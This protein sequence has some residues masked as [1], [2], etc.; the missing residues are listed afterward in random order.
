MKPDAES[1]P[2]NLILTIKAGQNLIRLLYY[3][4]LG[5]TI[6]C[7]AGIAI[8]IILKL[9]GLYSEF[10]MPIAIISGVSGICSWVVGN[11]AK[12]YHAKYEMIKETVRK[13]IN[14]NDKENI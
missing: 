13:S 2:D 10:I 6:I 9:L 12:P 3:L 5:L 1:D 7:W 14:E 11:I 4:Q 8:V